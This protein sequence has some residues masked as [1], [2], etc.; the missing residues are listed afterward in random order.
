MTDHS[1]SQARADAEAGRAWHAIEG[2]RRILERDPA[3]ADALAML[4][5]VLTDL[6]AK[7]SQACKDGRLGPAVWCFTLLAEY[8]APREQLRANRDALVAVML[9]RHG[10]CE[11]RTRARSPARLPSAACPRSGESPGASGRRTAGTRSRR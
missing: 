4:Q 3:N 11:C 5:A 7:G 6:F 9:A 10:R 1:V 2:L 8:G